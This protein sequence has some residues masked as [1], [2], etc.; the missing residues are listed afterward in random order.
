[1]EKSKQRKEEIDSQMISYRE[2]LHSYLHSQEQRAA[3]SAKNQVLQK[4]MRASNSNLN[5]TETQKK[6]LARYIKIFIKIG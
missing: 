2:D 3:D 1:M 5:K 6:N 4:R